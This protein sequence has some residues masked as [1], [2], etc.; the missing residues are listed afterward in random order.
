[1]NELLPGTEVALR[2]LR[3]EVVFVQPKGQ[4]QQLYRLR[5]LDSV[6][7]GRELDVLVPFEQPSVITAELNPQR[8]C[9][10]QEWRV[11]HDAFL[12]EQALGPNA[13][14]C[15][16][17]G[18]LRIAA[19]QLVPVLRALRMARPRLLLAD[20]VG[21]GKTIEAGLLLAELIA[22]RR[23]HRILI[24]S[25][26]GPLLLQWQQE[27]R[28]RF[29]LRFRL[30]DDD[31]LKDIRNR[32]ELGSNPF[33]QEALG[34]ISI[35]FAKQE[36]VL[37]DIERSQFDVVIIDEAHHCVRL[38]NAGDREDSLRRRL[39]EVL[40]A[41]T[42][43]LLLLTAT[44]HDGFDTHFASLIELLD[45]SLCDGRGVPRP[46][47][48]E[49]HVVRRLKRHIK[50][51]GTGQNM[52]QERHVMPVAV[53]FDP[54]AA[55]AFM[56]FHEA[57]LSLI[58]PELR[59]ALKKRAF[60][61]VLA[62]ISLLKRSVSTALAC[63]N[64]LSVVA[65]RLGELLKSGE[66]DMEERRQRIRTLRELER[67]RERM[68]GLSFEEEED[69][70]ML[71]ALDMAAELAET[72]AFELQEKLGLLKRETRREQEKNKRIAECQ[73]ALLSLEAMAR[74]AEDPKLSTLLSAIESI[75]KEEPSAN[76]LVYT[77]YADSQK[78]AYDY[79]EQA[80]NQGKI[81][82]LLLQ[83]RGQ[84]NDKERTRA[85]ESF[86]N[87]EG[88]V[89]ISTDAGAEGLNLHTRCHH[90]IHLELPYNPNR[91][92]Q[93]NGRIDRFGQRFEPRVQYLYLEGSF[94]ERLL[95]RLMMKYEAQ[96]KRLGFVP[97]TLGVSLSGD[98]AGHKLLEGLLS[99]EGSLFEAKVFSSGDMAS[100]AHLFSEDMHSA[101]YQ[102]ML[103]EIDRVFADFEKTSKT[104]AWL[105]D[106]GMNAD[107]QSLDLA[108]QAQAKGKRQNSV[109]LLSFVL[110]AVRA[111]SPD[112]HAVRELGDGVWE[113]SLPSAWTHGLEDIPGYNR[114]SRKLLLGTQ[115]EQTR[116]AQERPLGFLGRAH[117]LVRRALDRVR[118]IQFGSAQELLDR[119]VSSASWEGKEP[120]LLFSYLGRLM[121]GTGRELERVMAVLL[122]KDGRMSVMADPDS[123]TPW[124]QNKKAIS[125]S[126]LWQK[127]FEAWANTK[128]PQAE[129]A[130]LELF[131]QIC[132][133]FR[134]EF[135][136]ELQEAETSL[137]EWLLQRTLELM[138][139]PS[140]Q[141]G[142][143]GEEGGAMPRWK[144]LVN[145]VERLEAFG[146]DAAQPPK[147]RSEARVVLG[148][149]R[150]RRQELERRR[151]LAPPELRPLGLLMLVPDA[152][153]LGVAQ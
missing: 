11:F 144:V 36:K 130:A 134:A 23:A 73:Q 88:Q 104:H 10:L 55:P 132:E 112:P 102:D 40:A 140:R 68:G 54:K 107:S 34:L 15:V 122:H 76:I 145:P 131:S 143:F 60:G 80:L 111:D 141:V 5:C 46:G 92:E 9:R 127:H 33:D 52:F 56:A 50:E 25:P 43:A 106:A 51:P 110:D 2:G 82:G 31:A 20:D 142:L 117:P 121:S 1:M 86:T 95:L 7:R 125:S 30:L 14:L 6:L 37:K 85:T 18:R 3:W 32:S 118:H 128:N 13:F 136:G 105:G 101:A 135:L 67:R 77:E 61:D 138:G 152:S 78:A 99:D 45:P 71:E 119:R 109:D 91:L 63:A 84:D 44:P 87:S 113:L 4:E 65:A 116:D 42:D 47:R 150:Q 147:M 79:L 139:A 100:P 146:E 64:T 58:V 41:R 124:A 22:R 93:R 69:K 21:L 29:G 8:A 114:E 39:A 94:E 133:E 108:A 75:R 72:G 66:E 74:R 98:M 90:L 103:G 57:L 17:P 35:D 120:A 19:Y 126:G 96:R 12:L 149:H 53:R 48:Y 16:Q 137:Q 151:N 62:F 129:Q 26:A 24:V 38:G 59:R 97:N 27:M 70:A 89:L 148:L 81:S 83:I 49:K 28:E 153:G 115:A 123:W